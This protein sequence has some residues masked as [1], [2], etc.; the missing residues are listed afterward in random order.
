MLR[1]KTTCKFALQSQGYLP[2]TKVEHPVFLVLNTDERE[3]LEMVHDMNCGGGLI[4]IGHVLL[5]DI[6]EIIRHR[7]TT[8][9]DEINLFFASISCIQPISIHV[10]ELIPT[11]TMSGLASSSAITV[12]QIQITVQQT[13]TVRFDQNARHIIGLC[14]IPRMHSFDDLSCTKHIL[15][16]S[17]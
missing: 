10:R 16:Q 1:F 5:G 15:H 14:Q 9:N 3:L 11:Q 4:M 6:G 17:R 7:V 12:Q 8:T 2:H 13:H